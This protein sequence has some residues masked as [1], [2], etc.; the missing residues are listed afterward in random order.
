MAP[1]KKTVSAPPGEPEAKPVPHK[2][3]KKIG[4]TERKTLAIAIERLDE[5]LGKLRGLAAVID[6]AGLSEVV[7]EGPKL[8]PRGVNS[9]LSYTN[10]LGSALEN[11]NKM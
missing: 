2:S 1:K 5:L 3:K 6:A 4:P 11:R 7:M 10:K 8:L 9:L